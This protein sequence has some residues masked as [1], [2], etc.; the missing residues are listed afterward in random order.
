MNVNP[1]LEGTLKGVSTFITVRDTQFVGEGLEVHV[2]VSLT[3]FREGHIHIVTLNTVTCV[4]H[5]D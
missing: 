4:K 3:L 5:P 2:L 1:V